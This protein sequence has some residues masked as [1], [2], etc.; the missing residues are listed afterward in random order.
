MELEKDSEEKIK[1][2]VLEK[3][4]TGGRGE[5]DVPHTLC[6]VKWMKRLI[7]ENEGN[8]R[9]LIPTMY[10]HDSC[11]PDYKAGYSYEESR[12]MKEEHAKRGAKFAKKT[13]EKIGGFS[14]EE[15]EEIYRLVSIHDIHDDI[16]KDDLNRQLVFEADGLA[17]LDWEEC[18]PNFDK[19][20]CLKWVKKYFEV[21]RPIEL[22]RTELG[23]KSIQKLKIKAKA[24][25]VNI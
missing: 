13:L 4:G 21:E 8:E 23:K 16:K 5:W 12:K 14:Q 7:G 15:L 1:K 20:N 19:E 2:I 24:Y 11:Y 17:Q 9:V 18:P 6:S 3:I 25:W 22:W 10:F